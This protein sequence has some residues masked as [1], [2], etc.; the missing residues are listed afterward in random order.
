MRV[1]SGV[2]G[3]GRGRKRGRGQGYGVNAT[4]QASEFANLS[5]NSPVPR[6]VRLASQGCLPEGRAQ[7]R[8]RFRHTWWI[9]NRVN[10]TARILEAQGLLFIHS[11]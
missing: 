2:G 5:P 10:A 4:A 7:H 11:R 8:Q 9:P 1:R 3:R 6:P